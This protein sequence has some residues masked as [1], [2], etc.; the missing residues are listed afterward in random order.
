M[1]GFTLAE[2]DL[3]NDRYTLRVQTDSAQSNGLLAR[4]SQSDKRMEKSAEYR[5]LRCVRRYSE[6]IPRKKAGVERRN[7]GALR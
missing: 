5:Y 3:S 2:N 6:P 1:R 4:Y 7:E